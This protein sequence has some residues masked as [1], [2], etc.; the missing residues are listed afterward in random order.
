MRHNLWRGQRYKGNCY[1]TKFPFMLMVRPWNVVMLII[2]LVQMW[3][4]LT[5][6]RFSLVYNFVGHEAPVYSVCPY[7]DG[8]QVFNCCY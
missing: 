3:M 7:E 4:A 8:N 1:I 2:P 6:E 5:D